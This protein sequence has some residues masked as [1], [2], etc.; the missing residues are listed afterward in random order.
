MGEDHDHAQERP[1]AGLF[2]AARH[3][4]R[5]CVAGLLD[6][7]DELCRD[8][9]LR[10]TPNRRV[11]LECLLAD[12]KPLSAY[13]IAERIDWQGRRG[14]PVQVYRALRF[15]EDLGLV[16]RIESLNAFVACTHPVDGDGARHGAQFLVCTDC[17]RVAEASDPALRRDIGRMARQAGFQ[18][19]D[20]VIEI[21]GLCPDCG[22]RR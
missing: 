14:G 15:F 3:D 7:A 18:V 17:G 9:G 22:G 12:H 19:Q 5:A 13:D 21:K 8:Q 10:L 2:P 6:H 20:P 1:A 4:H 16:H 11:V